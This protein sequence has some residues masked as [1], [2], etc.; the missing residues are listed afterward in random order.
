MNER[1]AAVSKETENFCSDIY[2]LTSFPFSRNIAGSPDIVLWL[3]SAGYQ[4]LNP[5]KSCEHLYESLFA[6][7]LHVTMLIVI[8]GFLELSEV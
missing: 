4:L 7:N 2:G 6:P 1:E 3:F 5:P 8:Y